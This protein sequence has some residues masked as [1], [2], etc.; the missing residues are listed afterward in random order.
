MVRCRQNSSLFMSNRYIP[1]FVAHINLSLSYLSLTLKVETNGD[2]DQEQTEK[3]QA[4]LHLLTGG[5]SEA[6]DLEEVKELLRVANK[7]L[8]NFPGIFWASTAAC[9][10]HKERL[11]KLEG[12]LKTPWLIEELPADTV[13]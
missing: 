6:K 8:E 4:Q 9:R 5:M 1:K 3:L 12:L 7:L 10:T 13:Y 2:I 11:E